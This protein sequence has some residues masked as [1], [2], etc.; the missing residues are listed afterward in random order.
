MASKKADKRI[1]KSAR[2]RAAR[3][4]KSVLAVAALAEQ[5]ADWW[6]VEGQHPMARQLRAFAA[7]AREV[8][9]LFGRLDPPADPRTARTLFA[10][11]VIGAFKAAG[12]KG[13]YRKAAEVLDA[14]DALG[15]ADAES[16]K[17]LARDH[18]ELVDHFAK[19]IELADAKQFAR[20]PP[21]EAVRLIKALPRN[22]R[23]RREVYA[24]LAPLLPQRP[25][26][27]QFPRTMRALSTVS[28][29]PSKN[30]PPP[31]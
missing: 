9:F 31:Y 20:L 17:M 21:A 8:A 6:Q 23:L 14:L 16:L 27:M 12:A 1:R 15:E 3:E 4:K 5:T 13:I 2:G 11:S 7:H 28:R 25:A 10:C 19:A 24:A 29:A 18:R 30:G 22:S 26:P